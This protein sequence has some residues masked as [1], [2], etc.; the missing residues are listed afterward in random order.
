MKNRITLAILAMF[1]L[2]PVASAKIRVP[3]SVH[4]MTDLA[5]AQEEA[6]KEGKALAFVYTD[7]ASS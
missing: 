3:S 2:A 1:L 7:P 5:K 6:Q 4:Q